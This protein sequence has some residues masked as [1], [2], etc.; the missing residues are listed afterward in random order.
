VVRVGCMD[1]IYDNW[2]SK[3]HQ[4]RGEIVDNKVQVLVCVSMYRRW[5]DMME[6]KFR[7]GSSLPPVFYVL[8]DLEF[9]LGVDI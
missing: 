1:G 2:S 5:G 7:L 4:L 9:V 8:L 3:T 6:G